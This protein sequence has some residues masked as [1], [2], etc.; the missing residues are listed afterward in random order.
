MSK[1]A[2]SLILIN[3]ALFIGLLSYF[4]RSSGWNVLARNYRSRE[5]LQHAVRWFFV[6]ARMGRRE[7][8]P[9]LGVQKPLVP[10]RNAMNVAVNEEGLR[11][12]MFPLFRLFHPPLFFPWDHISTQSCSG[13]SAN[14]IEF[15]FREAPWVV[16][17]FR[18]S[19]AAE[20]LQHTPPQ[21][22]TG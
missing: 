20:L 19:M 3:V 12:S 11:L 22:L 6:S 15:H 14:W 18:K 10:L 4:Q 5:P 7:P 2:I 21:Y 17:R 13:L 8:N 9:L 16:L 1:E